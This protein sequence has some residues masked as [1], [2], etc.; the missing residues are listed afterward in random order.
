MLVGTQRVAATC[1]KRNPLLYDR[2][3]ERVSHF[4]T[5]LDL[6][7]CDSTE[8]GRA[9]DRYVLR[10]RR[11]AVSA[12]TPVCGRIGSQT[13]ALARKLECTAAAAA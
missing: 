12:A 4:L 10:E 8:G 1:V 11:P 5:S 6:A 3:Q 9:S 13:V 7:S 2:K